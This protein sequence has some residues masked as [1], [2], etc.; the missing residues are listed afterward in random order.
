[1]GNPLTS[2]VA[3]FRWFIAVLLGAASVGLVAKL[4]SPQAGIFWGM[5][6]IGVV[7]VLIANGM[8]YMLGSP[9]DDEPGEGDGGDNG[10][11]PDEPVEPLARRNGED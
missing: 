8:R 2:E 10:D 7:F 1:M 5:I 3:A 6:L 4:I 11:E 9:E